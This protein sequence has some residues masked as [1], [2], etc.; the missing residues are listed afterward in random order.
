[1]SNNV[2][3]FPYVAIQ[4][5]EIEAEKNLKYRK[6]DHKKL[7]LNSYLF[8]FNLKLN[9]I[10]MMP[11]ES[12]MLLLACLLQLK[13]LFLFIIFCFSSFSYILHKLFSW[14]LFHFCLKLSKFCHLIFL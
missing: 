3:I 6:K 11:L 13:Y 12:V 1:M 9:R 14:L 10:H 7:S 5:A 2:Q 4:T 8:Y